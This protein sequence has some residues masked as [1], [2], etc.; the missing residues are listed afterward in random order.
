MKP[1][2]CRSLV[3]LALVN[4]LPTH[5]AAFK[6]GPQEITVADGFVVERATTPGLVERPI[7]ADFDEQG[8]LYVAES[9]G[10]NDPV[11]KQLEER[12]HSILRLSDSDGDGIFDE[13]VVFADKMMFPEGAMWLN[14]S[15]YVSAPPSIWKLTDSD[16]DGVADQREE[17]YDAKTLTGCA[18]D[19]HGPYLGPDGWIY[20]CKGAFARQ[21]HQLPVGGTFETRAA[22]IFRRRPEGGGVEPVMT[23]GMDNPVDVVFTPEGERIFTSTFFQHPGGGQRD[24]LIHAIYGGRYGKEHDV[25]DDHPKTGELMPVLTHLG[26]AAPAGFARY[27]SDRFGPEFQDDLFA[28]LFNLHKVTRHELRPNGAT[29]ETADS[30]FLVSDSTDFHPTDVIEDADGSLLVIDTGGWYKLCCPT[31]Q[32]WKPDVLGAIYR[33]RKANAAPL[34]DPRG[35]KLIWENAA[36]MAK[37][38]DDPRPA[39]RNRAIQEL[40]RKGEAAIAPLKEILAQ[41]KSIAARRNAVWALAQI[42]SPLAREATRAALGDSSSSV[43]HAAIHSASVWRDAGALS[44]LIECLRNSDPALKRAAAEALGRV[45]E[46]R[47]VSPLL[48][49][50]AGLDGI[51][52]GDARRVLEHSLI[53]A[54]IEIGAPE[55]TRRGLDSPSLSVRK[56]ALIALDQMKD[57]ALESELVTGFLT[58]P[59]AVLR[60]TAEWITAQ[61]AD[62]GDALARHYEKQLTDARA[63]SGQVEELSLQLSRLA[64]SREIQALLARIALSED[65]PAAPRITAL[66]AMTAARLK[67]PPGEW[68]KAV[69]AALQSEYQPLTS[70]AVQAAGTLPEEQVPASLLE[71][72]RKLTV[73]QSLPAQLRLD[74][75]TASVRGEL[76]EQPFVFLLEQFEGEK[77][78]ELRRRALGILSRSKL[79]DEQL[80]RLAELAGKITPLEMNAWLALFDKSANAQVG[81]KLLANLRNARALSA[82]QPDQLRTVLT[83]Y[84]ESVREQ[85]NE[86]VRSLNQDYEQQLA[87]INELLPQLANGDLRRGQEIFNS[88]RAACSSCHAIGYL[89]GNF[90]PDLTRI[91]QIRTERDLLE[92]VVYP[93]ASLVRSYEPV[94]LVTK[95]DEEYSGILRKDA[96]DEVMLATGPGIEVRVPRDEIAE[97]RPGKV[98]V[99]PQGLD[100][101]L[102]KQ[103][104]ADLLAFLKATKW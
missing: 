73:E 1:V 67:E 84:P 92:A 29:F 42:N 96:P 16:G 51:E 104:L 21:V 25:L 68:L 100:Q 98:S 13:R 66:R 37:R 83:K 26:P 33:V 94:I 19:L 9:S 87:H 56:A 4:A 71:R 76:E 44:S 8:R 77:P 50:A 10:S 63:G 52:P 86:L 35:L 28:A 103:E 48:A 32:L 80:V 11:K 40:G 79:A 81:L 75:L 45:G 18:N 36:E 61:H 38:L 17:W 82:V 34:A 6:F 97:M 22:H 89:G 49:E 27:E 30:D 78:G 58:S 65:L 74:A 47:A 12:P 41:S 85:G 7:V 15:L 70:A 54:L 101:Q 43:R 90:G 5:G 2:L 93:S 3:L 57:G 95:Q 46:A 55:E 91:G 72:L 88:T 62:W 53:F 64:E 59:S 99:M 14:G 24:G 60:Q 31:S 20:W 39:V 23:G 102:T 69:D